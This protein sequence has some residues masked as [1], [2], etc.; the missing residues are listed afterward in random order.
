[1]MLDVKVGDKLVERSMLG[2]ILS[3]QT[4]ERLTRTQCVLADGTR[5]VL[6]SGC[7]VGDT[8]N[9]GASWYTVA[10]ADDIAQ[11]A[12]AQGR[13]DLLGRFARLDRLT[14]DQLRQVA[15]LI[16]S[17]KEAATE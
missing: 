4:V 16:E 17:F 11:F 15:A 5:V 9:W 13:K 6:R 12:E 2:K 3:I 8:A 1:M 14:T 10:T 7:R